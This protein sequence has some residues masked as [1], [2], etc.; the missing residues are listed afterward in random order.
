MR[1]EVQRIILFTGGMDS[2]Y[3]LLKELSKGHHIIAL[4]VSSE[5][6]QNNQLQKYAIGKIYRMIKKSKLD[7]K[8]LSIRFSEANIP[9][10]VYGSF[11]R[12]QLSG[13]MMPC[14]FLPHS[15]Y[16]LNE[17]MKNEIIL[18]YTSEDDMITANPTLP[19]LENIQTAL[20]SL[21][22][23]MTFN[24]TDDFKLEVKT[25]LINKTKKDIIKD[26]LDLCGEFSVG[27][28]RT[29]I[30]SNLCFCEKDIFCLTN[31]TKVNFCPSCKKMYPV[32]KELDDNPF[33]F[34]E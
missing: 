10:Q 27:S 32:L 23:L 6:F 24:R 16:L 18:S 11:M 2:T 14:L 31:T 29:D 34:M 26:L 13:L 12:E 3:S 9:K 20:E 5:N 15:L 22:T 25:P 30:I 4:Y 19:K 33:S 28:K 21:A 7:E 1:D 8:L 17:S